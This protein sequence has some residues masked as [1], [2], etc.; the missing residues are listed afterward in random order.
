[1]RQ[2]K[3]IRGSVRRQCL[4]FFVRQ[5]PMS[6]IQ[7]LL[8]GIPASM[9]SQK[10]VSHLRRWARPKHWG[11]QS[12]EE[13]ESVV[14]IT[15][16]YNDININFVS[17]FSVEI[18][19]KSGKRVNWWFVG[20]GVPVCGLMKECLRFFFVLVWM[21][22]VWSETGQLR[23]PRRVDEVAKQILFASDHS[24]G[25]SICSQ[26]HLFLRIW[27]GAAPHLPICPL[28]LA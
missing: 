28:S 21:M 24:W 27:G 9:P 20:F 25:D 1:M 12:F 6:R 7:R 17:G 5:A 23:R 13:N 2:Q 11:Q 19:R 8:L 14:S 22:F 16:R 18:K 4:V 15:Q 26:L 3:P 10:F